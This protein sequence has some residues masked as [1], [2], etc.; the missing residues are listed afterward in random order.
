MAQKRCLG[1]SAQSRA[2]LQHAQRC[3]KEG[4]GGAAGNRGSKADNAVVEAGA[5]AGQWVRSNKQRAVSKG[6]T[7]HVSMLAVLGAVDI[8]GRREA[9][10][11][12]V[13]NCCIEVCT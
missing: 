13:C 6:N 3:S 4:G 10:H 2:C 9:C 7:G 8:S 1:C 5:A 11:G 12:G